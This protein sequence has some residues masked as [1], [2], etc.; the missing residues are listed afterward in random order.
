MMDIDDPHDHDEDHYDHHHDH[1]HQHPIDDHYERFQSIKLPLKTI[2]R[3]EYLLAR[4]DGYVQTMHQIAV[5]SLQ[6]LKLYYLHK[7][8]NG[9]VLDITWKLVE[10][11]CRTVSTQDPRG[12][13]AGAAAQAMRTELN[14]FYNTCYWNEGVAKPQST[15]LNTAIQYFV[16]EVLT[17]YKNKVKQRFYCC[18]EKYMAHLMG[19]TVSILEIEEDVNLTQQQKKLAKKDLYRR[20][21]RTVDDVFVTAG[22]MVNGTMI[23]N[24]GSLQLIPANQQLSHRQFLDEVKSVVLPN[25]PVANGNIFYDL[26]T[27]PLRYFSK[28][29]FMMRELEAFGAKIENVFPLRTSKIPGHLRIDTTTLINILF[30]TKYH[31]G[32]DYVMGRTGGVTRGYATKDKYLSENKDNLWDT[33]FKCQEKR[34]VFHGSVVLDEGH[35]LV[36][37][38]YGNYSTD[39]KYTFRHQILTDGISC[40]VL[41]VH[42]RDAH[43]IHPENPP[44][45]PIIEQ[46][47]HQ[48]DENTRQE[49]QGNNIVAID[50]GMSDLLY[51]VD[52]AENKEWRYTQDQRRF[53]T[54]STFYKNQLK[55]ERRQQL[56]GVQTVEHVESQFG[57]ANSRKVLTYVSF[58]AYCHN[59]NQL[60]SQVRPFYSE[61]KHRKRRFQRYRKRQRSEAK[62]LVNFKEKFGDPG[63]TTVCIGDWS[64]TH[65]RKFVEPVKGKGFRKLFKKAGYQVFLVDE[66]RTSTMC[67]NCEHADARCEEFRRVK[68]P[69]PRSRVDYPITLCRGLLRCTTCNTLWNRDVLGA[70]NIYKISSSAING[71]DRPLYLR[72]Q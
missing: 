71:D 66:Y 64:E 52:C 26:K 15:H 12:R 48:I 51:A 49:L 46:Y 6:F 32:Y 8:E 60:V 53:E 68:N 4:F 25:G 27:N 30:P 70:T 42:K 20:N 45:A 24:Y 62:M 41:L 55:S 2:I 11:I 67:S 5:H 54:G 50:P 36:D 39:H 29:V 22:H 38:M 58:R 3:H 69:K 47:I 18:V 1:H 43:L 72:R 65:H 35:P 34:Q 59:H 17:M 40:T 13:P 61:H 9:I 63:V 23:Y 16:G 44:N 28:M 7:F 31:E 19:T 21:R 57:Q 33:F 56:I 14:N 10:N 37:N